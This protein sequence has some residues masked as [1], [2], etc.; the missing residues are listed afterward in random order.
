MRLDKGEI[1]ENSDLFREIVFNHV[2]D[3]VMNQVF[4]ETQEIVWAVEGFLNRG[5]S[6]MEREDI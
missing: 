1:I 4:N 5:L 6:T 3:I 2:T